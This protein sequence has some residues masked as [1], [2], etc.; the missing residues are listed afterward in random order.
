MPKKEGIETEKRLSDT[1]DYLRENG[2]NSKEIIELVNKLLKV[3]S[4]TLRTYVRS[5]FSIGL[6]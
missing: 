1:L 3:E 4:E 6:V 2:F 5:L